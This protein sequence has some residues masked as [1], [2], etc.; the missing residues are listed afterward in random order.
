[1]RRVGWSSPTERPWYTCHSGMPERKALRRPR[2]SAL[3]CQA[4]HRRAR[5]APPE[6]L[7]RFPFLSNSR[8]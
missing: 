7:N 4:G 8:L 3:S 6:P 1:M 5:A 2:E